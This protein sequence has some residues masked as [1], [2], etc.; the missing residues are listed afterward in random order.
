MTT[1]RWLRLEPGRKENLEAAGLALGVAAGVA[2]LV[3][4]FGRILMSRERVH[5]RGELEAEDSA[6]E[7]EAAAPRLP[8][9][10]GRR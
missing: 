9:S 1:R 4:Y 7:P 6:P 8:S 2:A 10:A 5:R 3:F